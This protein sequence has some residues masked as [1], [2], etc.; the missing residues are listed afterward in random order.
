MWPQRARAAPKN[1][2]EPGEP[3]APDGEAPARGRAARGDWRERPERLGP[4]QIEINERGDRLSLG[5]GTQFLTAVNHAFATADQ[6]RDTTAR[7]QIRRLRV[8]FGGE[9]VARKIQTKLQFNFAPN[10]PELIDVWLMY[11]PFRQLGIKF[12]QF[13]LPYTRY[14]EQSFA[15]L[16][17]A[18]WSPVTRVFGS[19]RQVGLALVQPGLDDLPWEY[20]LG[21]YTGTNA[22]ASHGLGVIEQYGET[23]EN[24]SD[25][26]TF[27]AA[28]EIHPELAGRVA[29]NFGGID[30]SANSDLQRG[31][32]RH[33]VGVS[34]AW[35]VR[36]S[37]RQDLAGRLALEWLAKLHGVHFNAVGHLGW[38]DTGF[39]TIFG[40]WGG[41]LE[42]GYR[43]D[44]SWELTARYSHVQFVSAL[45]DD[46]R[47]YAASQIGDGSDPTLV[48]QYADVGNVRSVDEAA[49]AGTYDLFGP[50]LRA[51]LEAAWDAANT[52]MGWRQAL[53]L[54]L[55]LQFTF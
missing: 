42:T 51:Q 48:T 22:R 13:K 9:F 6:Q 41:L 31:P 52:L 40:T 23:P 37:P 2:A 18:D 35:D 39:E 16:S 47:I 32:L 19:E 33:S 50:S 7:V 43:F 29:R 38:V 4:V 1:T 28:Y 25:F 24:P 11:A 14:R 45:R 55:Q 12:G 44:R 30:T 8:S 27:G 54:R 36:P 15:V 34:G 21:V 17:N 10:A 49:L 46:A 53:V 5:L 3:A 20:G 26:R